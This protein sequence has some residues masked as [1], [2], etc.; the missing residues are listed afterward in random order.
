MK[1]V[2]KFYTKY[3]HAI[4]MI[5][6]SI[7]YLVWFNWLERNVTGHYRLIHMNFDDYIPFCEYFIIPYFL[8][9]GYVAVTVLFCMFKD[10]DEYLRL[11]ITLMIGMTVFLIISTLWPNGHRLR[12][13]VFE[14]DNMFT[15]LVAY[16]Y[17]ID[18]PTNLWP[19][20]HVY[21]SLVC[22]IAIVH[23]KVL[24][25]KKGIH[26]ASLILAISIIL[27]TVFLKQHSVFDV[28]TA[29]IMAAIVYTF[30]YRRDLIA[31]VM[32]NHSKKR[33]GPQ[34]E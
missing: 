2:S 23:S 28:S 10:K 3:K 4:P 12:P 22:H 17:K 32:H 1:G 24:Q 13:R 18:T 30:V 7:V 20:I 8:W 27:S 16:L 19:S 6:Y 29:F 25:N 15:Q 5:I 9:F 31:S 33:P 34:I 14:R 11:S 21:N 26:I